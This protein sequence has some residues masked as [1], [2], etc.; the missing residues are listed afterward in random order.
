MRATPVEAWSQ[1]RTLTGWVGG[2][3]GG[4]GRRQMASAGDRWGT[5]RGTGDGTVARAGTAP[6]RPSPALVLLPTAGTTGLPPERHGGHQRYVTT[7]S[8]AFRGGSVAFV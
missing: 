3:G 6:P 4:Q 5:G 7:H 8:L 1:N 2:R